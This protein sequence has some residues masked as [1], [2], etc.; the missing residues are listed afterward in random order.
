MG[1]T[2]LVIGGFTNVKA[3]S[4]KE[5]GGEFSLDNLNLFLIFDRFSRFRVVAEMQLKD[6][7]LAD[8]QGAGTR[9]FAFDVRRLFAE[10]AISDEV[11]VRA[12]TFLTPVGYWNLLRAPPLTWTTEPPLIVEE[13]FFQ[14]TTTGVML[15]AS[16]EVAGGELGC[17]AF[18]QFLSPLENDPDLNPP[19]YTAGLRLEYDVRLA[20]SV[21][22]TYQA[23]ENEGKWSH[24]AGVHLMWQHR[25][26][27][28]LSEFYFQDVENLSTKEHDEPSSSQ[29]GTYLQGVFDVYGPFHLVGR[30]E[31]FDP[32]FSGAAVNVFTVGGVWK[33]FPF[34]AVKI[35]YRVADHDT[36]EGS[37]DG[38][39]S[40]FTTF[41]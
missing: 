32:P 9:D 23:A 4:A 2:G 10:L 31:H 41:F 33:P 20:W 39:F 22:A 38:F 12:G 7:F 36:E 5:T 29:W 40:S 28:I 14:P 1:S 16:T 18:S 24:L 27:E 6:V 30:Y 13:T 3:E 8:G 25:R 26:G 15:D 34:Q 19:D 37:L 17:S 35:E 21:G 11:H